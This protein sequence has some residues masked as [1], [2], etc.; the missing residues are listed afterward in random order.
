ML[1]LE[2]VTKRFGKVQAVQNVS[3]TVQEG[4]FFSLL[5][6]SGCGKTS[7]LR[8]VAG[9][10]AA[11]SGRILLKGADLSGKPMHARDIALVFQNYALFPHL[12]IFENVAFGLVMRKVPRAEIAARV[13]EALALVRMQGFDARKP[14]ELSGGQQQRI[15]LAR[16]V[17]VQP[18]LL[19]LDEPLSNLDAK[20]RDEMREEIHA[21][22]RKLRLT[23]ILVTHDLREAF[24]VSDRVA[25]MGSGTVEQVGT[26]A[27]IYDNPA[28]HFV[29]SFVGHQNIF[30]GVTEAVDG[31]AV[32]IAGD[33]GLKWRALAGEKTWSVGGRTWGTIRPERIRV[34][35]GPHTAEVEETAYLGGSVELRLRLGVTRLRTHAANLGQAIPRVGETVRIGWREEDVIA[36]PELRP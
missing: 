14:S 25:V 26:P 4:E 32:S 22:Q 12:T 1:T 11:D 33:D 9:I 7:L 31:G 6:P 30:R 20:L 5:G 35:D 8:T 19:L 10:Y 36:A 16:A 13:S 18:S 28:S 17:V 21:L 2:G 23:T 24:A 34:G 29:A 15:A 27:E 3:L